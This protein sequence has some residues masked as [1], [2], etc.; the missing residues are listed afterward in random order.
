MA[1]T[2]ASDEYD[3]IRLLIGGDIDDEDLKDSQIDGG[4]VLGAAESFVLRRDTGWGSRIKH[5]RDTR[6]IGEPFC[7]GARGFWCR[8]SHSRFKRPQGS[9][10]HGIRRTISGATARDP[11]MRKWT[12][13]FRSWWTRGMA[14]LRMSSWRGLRCFGRGNETRV[15]NGEGKKVSKRVVFTFEAESFSALENKK[16]GI[17]LFG[18]NGKGFA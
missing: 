13:I 14:R 7:I 15:R 12:R 16:M 11:A 18:R 9:Y 10:Q 1:V 8:R 17:I 2:L 3:E 6:R 5:L 4:T